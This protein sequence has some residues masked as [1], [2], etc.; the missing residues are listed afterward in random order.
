MYVHTYTTV[1][2]IELRQIVLVQRVIIPATFQS[3]KP[4][5]IELEQDNFQGQS[6]GI[7]CENDSD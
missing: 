4:K 5:V 6:P 1:V 7:T 3:P 2:K